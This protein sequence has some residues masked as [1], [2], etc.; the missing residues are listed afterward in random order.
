MSPEQIHLEV[1]SRYYRHEWDCTDKGAFEIISEAYQRNLTIT[2]FIASLP[3]IPN[4][5]EEH[6]KFFCHRYNIPMG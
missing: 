6:L 1:V 5:S 3:Y 4:S 2:Q